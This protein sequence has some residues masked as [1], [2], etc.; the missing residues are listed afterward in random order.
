MEQALAG[1]ARIVIKVG[2]STLTHATGKLNLGRMETLARELADLAN[3]GH[4]PILVTS[5][6]VAAGRGRL[7]LATRP[8]SLPERQAVAAVGQGLLMQIYEKLFGEYSQVVAQ[9]L[10]TRDDARDR[11]RYLNARHTFLTLLELGVIPIVNENDTVAT[12]ELQFGEN[13]TLSAMVAALVEADLLILISDVDAVYTSDPR[14]DPDARPRSVIEEITP[15]ILA[16][17][18]GAGSSLGTGGMLTKIEAA[19]IATSSGCLMA[20]IGGEPPGTMRRLLQGE[21]VGTVFLPRARALQ[22]REQWIAFAQVAAGDLVVDAGAARAL[23]ERGKSLLPSGLIEVRGDFAPGDLVRVIGPD[24]NEVARG[25]VNYNR[26]DA[27]KLIGRRTAEIESLLGYKGY[28][29][30]IHRDNLVCL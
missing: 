21:E 2:S 7:G 23:R 13:D 5:G 3:A 9:V 4:R 17:A 15:E 10:L 24:G 12:E 6:A 16:S 22:A 30:I 29:E 19:R 26:A 14:R 11:R 18:G 27:V 20:L 28:D 25:L 1:G 8:R